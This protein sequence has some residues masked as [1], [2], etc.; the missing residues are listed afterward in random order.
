MAETL[1]QILNLIL[2]L[3]HFRLL[4]CCKL[5]LTTEEKAMR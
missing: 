5:K 4:L 2:L 3:V 1:L